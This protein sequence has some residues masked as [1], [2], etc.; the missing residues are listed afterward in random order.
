MKVAVIYNK[1]LAD[2]DSVINPFGRPN[3]EIYNPETVKKVASALEKGGHTVK[4]FDG[5]MHLADK[6]KGFMPKVIEG[7]RPG[8]VFN[9]AYGIQG[10]SRY[11]HIPAMLEMLG[12]PY[13]GSGPA[14][15]A[16]ALDKVLTKI[17]FQKYGLPTPQFWVFNSAQEVLS[18]VTYPVI[19]KPKMEAVSFGLRVVDNIDDLREAVEFI[20][21][22]FSQSAL[23]EQFIPGREFAVGILGNGIDAEVLP[24][25]EID[26]NNDPNA[27]QTV[28]H[29]L[30]KPKEKICPANVDDELKERI[31]HLTRKAFNSLGLF[32][33]SRVDFR[34]DMEGNLYLLEINSMASLGRTGSYVRAAA[35][36]GLNFDAMI[37]RMLDT[38][39]IRYFGSS[40]QEL[41]VNGEDK[42]KGKAIKIRSFIRSQF[43][44]IKDNIRKMINTES[45]VYNTEGVNELGNWLSFKLKKFGFT[46]EVFN[47]NEV[48]N[49]LYFQNHSDEKNDF[50]MLG[51][52]DTSYRHKDM[53]EYY[54]RR[55][56]IYGSGAT[57]NKGGLAVMLAA[58]GA[59][60]YA[61]S[62]R[63]KKI[64]ILI[65]TDDSIGGKYSADVIHH[66]SLRSARV[67]GL[68][69]GDMNNGVVVSRAG[70][71]SF[72]V[73][74]SNTKRM[75]NE[76]GTDIFELVA[77]KILAIKKMGK[78][79]PGQITVKTASS[80]LNYGLVA[81]HAAIHLT[82]RYDSKE[83]GEEINR[84][85]ENLLRKGKKKDLRLIIKKRLL[86]PR[87]RKARRI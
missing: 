6:L 65:T 50:L 75:G 14:A 13:V 12:V 27:I 26:L 40:N 68:K 80:E 69:Y 61:R 53:V 22:E 21:K 67:I 45:Y 48:G 35:T 36:A 86:F 38:A 59:L 47:R 82:T 8:M 23:V 83:A 30:E 5:D 28:Q 7:D 31:Q 56:R 17:I 74:L 85:L 9:M 33:F 34:M 32:D 29:K 25:V 37:N 64:G 54:E 51:H 79:V 62:L 70:T 15:H 44:E 58:L 20:T 10:E 3:K 76:E 72:E 84:E 71:S 24:I 63:S 66:Y 18:D 19:V 81:D 46:R 41:L 4:I 73:E 55:G 42:E 87:C 78:E 57:E 43:P 11:T 2:N 16:V 52:L 49:C 60:R 39:A 1:G 77:K